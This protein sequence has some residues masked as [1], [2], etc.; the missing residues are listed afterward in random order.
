MRWHDVDLVGGWWLIP[1]ASS[2]NADPHRV[3][4]TSSVLEILERA[5]AKNR[6]KRY[7]FSNHRS[8][9]VVDRAK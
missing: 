7:V 3:P 5:T 6:D 9:C 1:A 8:T 2:K 4:L